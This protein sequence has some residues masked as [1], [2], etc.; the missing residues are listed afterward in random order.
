MR[1]RGA[2]AVG[3]ALP[4]LR[5]SSSQRFGR[6]IAPAELPFGCPA[7]AGF[8]GGAPASF[9]G[10]A[11]VMEAHVAERPAAQSA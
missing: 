6:R 7:S 5:I 4:S 3:G 2:S 9:D 1:G 10:A 11:L 8:A